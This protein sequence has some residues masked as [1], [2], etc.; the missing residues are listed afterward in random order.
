[1]ATSG[2]VPLAMRRSPEKAVYRELWGAVIV[3]SS[4]RFIPG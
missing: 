1:V 3:I 2:S 4:R